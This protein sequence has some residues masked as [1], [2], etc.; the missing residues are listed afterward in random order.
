ML[1]DVK[2]ALRQ[3][4]ARPLFALTAVLT[5]AIG[6]G[7]NAV[8]FSVV[9]GLLIKG[10]ALRGSDDLGRIATTPAGDE[11]GYS[12]LAEYQRFAEVTR[13]VLQLAAEGRSSMAWRHESVT[14][15]A[16]VL[17][18]SPDYFSML[19]A[20]ALLGRVAVEGG[21]DSLP[22]VVIGERFWRR[23]LGAPSITG[24]TLQL[25]GTLV[26][27]AGVLPE[28]FAGPAGIYSPDVWLPLEDLD[29]FSTSPALQKR[30]QRWLFVLARLQPGASVPEAQ[31]RVDAAAAA[32]AQ[33]WPDTH[34][35]RGARFRLFKEGNS[36]LSRLSTA[37]AAT[38]G[39]IGLVLLLACFNVAN[40]LLARAVERERDMAIRAAIGA[41]AG[42]LIRLVTIEG[43]IIAALAGMAALAIAF[44][45]QTLVG[46]FAIPIAQ[47]QYIDLRPDFTV[48][49]FIALL[50]AIAGILPGL[51]PAMRAARVDVLR[52]LASQGGHS[53]G[54]RPS[55]ARRWLVGA[56][57]AGSTAFLAMAVLFAQSYGHVL[58]AD[59][60][61]ARD[62]LIVAEF[63]PASHGYDAARSQRYVE[64]L[65]ARIR[66]L[67]GVT[68]T[69]AADRV[70]FFIG[71]ERLTAV[72]PAGSR[73]EAERCP[74][75][76]TMAVAPGYF[77][78]LGIPLTVGHEFEADRTGAVVINGPL[79][80][81]LFP[82]G[83]GL[84]ETVRVGEQNSPAT[85]IGIT[86]K[87]QTRGLSREQ[88]TLYV[89]L[90]REAFERGL[91]VVARTA[92]PP[93]RLLLA[94][95][96]A[97]HALDPNV[98]MR[99]LQTMEQRME[100]QMWP[101]RT[102]SWLFSICG[103]LAL[104]LS[105]VGLAAVVVHAVTQR[106]REFGVRVSVGA[107]PRHL[108]TDVMAGG[109]RLL[110]PGVVA[111]ALLAGIGAR[112]VQSAF[113]AVNVLD[114]TAYLLVALLQCGVVLVAC[115]GPAL[116]ASRVDPLV[117]LRAE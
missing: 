33:G 60:G 73:C 53:A 75:Y 59:T 44:W 58:R 87:A 55:P 24:L 7:V 41:G 1:C 21:R 112:L 38:M 51:W 81:L 3:L 110:I 88:P 67:P 117:A 43:F 98:S 16:W 65:L 39:L 12:S 113:V 114:P 69:A 99:S 56:Q 45:T 89:P 40:L 37:A 70:P 66:Q 49:A 10:R 19:D 8:A 71:F 23:K 11:T 9:N 76:A 52:A 48:V 84:A 42:R 111:G 97:A 17:F 83:G 85:V 64:A 72:S 86:A 106:L 34:R 5:L 54:G 115:I 36:E 28:S 26:A 14:E 109:I 94:F 102:V 57:I 32:M 27:V 63:E 104:V 50:V 107:T 61:F 31:S 116:R 80:R 30:D 79:A 29:L 2:L 82:A 46:H 25:N 105:V 93:D 100:V 35:T 103:A 74:R 15:T 95:A 91:S 13:G 47:P 6:I 78:T 101:F 20:G 4:R 92:L 62:R 22:S 18:V 90:E 96:E 108:V 77:R 68:D